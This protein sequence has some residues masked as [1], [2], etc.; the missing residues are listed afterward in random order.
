MKILFS[1][2][3]N[4]KFKTTDELEVHYE[5]IRTFSEPNCHRENCTYIEEGLKAAFYTDTR[6]LSSA[7]RMQLQV[8]PL[9][10]R[11]HCRDASNL[12]TSIHHQR[13]PLHSAPP[14]LKLSQIIHLRHNGSA[15][16]EGVMFAESCAS[17]VHL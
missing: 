15:F 16:A 12:C 4:S 14:D 8:K 7:S 13:A 11:R 5:F 3:F 10:Q 17:S 6:K 1:V 9:E 2:N